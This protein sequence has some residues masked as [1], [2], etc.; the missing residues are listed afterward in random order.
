[1]SVPPTLV[2]GRTEGLPRRNGELVFCAP[3]EARAFGLAVVLCR[4]QGLDWEAFRSRLIAE[5][6]AWEHEPAPPGSQWS[7]YERWLA[8]LERLLADF[9]LIGGPELAA[10]AERLAGKA[11]HDHEHGHDH[12]HDDH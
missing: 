11:A 9:D 1:M 6:G 2:D 8:A 10:R 5:I 7:Y 3:W 12:H 4:E